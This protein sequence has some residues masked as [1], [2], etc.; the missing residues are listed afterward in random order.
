MSAAWALALQC[1]VS[2]SGGLLFAM[3]AHLAY[4]LGAALLS[5]R[6]TGDPG[7]LAA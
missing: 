7:E 2:V 3:L 6:L 1:V 4:D 5:W